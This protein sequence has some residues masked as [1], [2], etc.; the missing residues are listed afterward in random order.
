MHLFDIVFVSWDARSKRC[1][2]EGQ[3]KAQINLVIK[4]ENVLE[5]FRASAHEQFD[6]SSIFAII[7]LTVYQAVEQSEHQLVQ[8][9]GPCGR[10]FT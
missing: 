2:E 5:D 7:M 1:F 10:T 6:Y 8:A 4:L 9:L 3:E